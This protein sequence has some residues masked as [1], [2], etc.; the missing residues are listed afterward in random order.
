MEKFN[1]QQPCCIESTLPQLLKKYDWLP[2]QTSGDVTVEKILKAVSYLAGNNLDIIICL[3]AIDVTILRLFAWYH[4]RGWL[5]AFTVL[6]ATDQS[7]LI[8]NELPKELPLTIVDSADIPEN[9][10]MLV[11]KG[12]LS[13]VI[14]NGPLFS[15]VTPG[16]CSYTAYYGKDPERIAQLTDT[17]NARIR[18][19]DAKKKRAARKTTPKKKGTTTPASETPAPADGSTV[20]G[21]SVAEGKDSITPAASPAGTNE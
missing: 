12:E 13:N 14:V 15:A 8:R 16:I 2:F 11:I 3:P 17:I 6:T 9:Y 4:R 5:K 10:G 20:L 1:Y 18:V 19:A 7:E 21:D